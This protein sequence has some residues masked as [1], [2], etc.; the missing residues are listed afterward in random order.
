M[1]KSTQLG[2]PVCSSKKQ[3]LFLSVSVDDT[4][5]AGKKQNIAPMWKKFLKTWILMNP[6]PFLI[7][8]IWDVLNVN[9]NQMK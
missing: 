6:H 2:M 1:G 3:G 4:K 7:M 5:M 8:Y 9:A